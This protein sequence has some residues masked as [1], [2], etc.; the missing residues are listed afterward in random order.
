MNLDQDERMDLLAATDILLKA[1][2]ADDWREC[3]HLLQLACGTIDRVANE[4]HNR[5]MVEGN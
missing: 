3:H 1:M 2:N 5:M 4:F